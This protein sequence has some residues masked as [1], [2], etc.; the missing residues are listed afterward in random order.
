MKDHKTLLVEMARACNRYAVIAL[1]A[2]DWAVALA[3]MEDRDDYMA[4]ARR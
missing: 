1:K 4:I 2:K 3:F